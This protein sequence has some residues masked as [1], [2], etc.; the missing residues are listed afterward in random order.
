MYKALRPP[1][2]L[3]STL[4]VEVNK[5]T[6]CKKEVMAKEGN[7]GDRCRPR[8][9]RSLWRIEVPR[10]HAGDTTDGAGDVGG[11]EANRAASR[12]EV[13]ET[14]CMACMAP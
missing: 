14:I 3:A 6:E 10:P 1:N 9:S 12:S 11:I 8:R 13:Q 5:R 4:Q 7:A 2:T